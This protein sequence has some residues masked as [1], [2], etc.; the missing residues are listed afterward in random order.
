MKSSSYLAVFGISFPSIVCHTHT[1][2][3]NKIFICSYKWSD[4]I[5]IEWDCRWWITIATEQQNLRIFFSICRANKTPTN[6][7]LKSGM[8]GV[9]P[10]FFHLIRARIRM[11]TCFGIQIDST[12]CLCNHVIVLL[13]Y[14]S[15]SNINIYCSKTVYSMEM[16]TQRP[17]RCRIK[18]NVKHFHTRWERSFLWCE[19]YIQRKQWNDRANW[20]TTIHYPF[21]QSQNECQNTSAHTRIHTMCAWYWYVDLGK[22]LWRAS[23]KHEIM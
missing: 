8:S 9:A 6:I 22:T 23:C 21:T 19:Q 12:V 17:Y 14:I 2:S 10:W 5:H 4:E 13:S 18:E 7:P 15:Q 20:R 1:E 11:R 16:P 3:I